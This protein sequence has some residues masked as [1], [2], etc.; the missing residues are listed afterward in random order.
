MTAR[1][2]IVDA[3]A[4]EPD[5]TLLALDFD[6]TLSPIVDDPTAAYIHPDSLSAV[7]SLATRLGRVAIVTGRPVQQVRKLGRFAETAGLQQVEIFGQYG[8]ERWDAATES[9]QTVVSGGAI[10]EALHRLKHLL[11]ELNLDDVHIE[12]KGLAVALHTRKSAPGTFEKILDPVEQIAKEL[13]LAV[14]PGRHVIEVRSVGSD[15]GLAVR[16]LLEKTG[17]TQVVYIGDDLGDRPAFDAIK[18]MRA[19]GLRGHL[20]CSASAE[21]QALVPLA[22]V[23]LDGPDGVAQWLTDLAAA[24]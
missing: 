5:H 18:A 13:D 23:V 3:V 14:E 1:S 7:A 20:L 22:D 9:I 6:G 8:A 17:A 10:D 11:D 24:L 16:E 19:D 21:Q 2:A 12:E 4:K 15:K